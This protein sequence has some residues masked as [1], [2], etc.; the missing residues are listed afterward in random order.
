WRAVVPTWANWRRRRRDHG[1]PRHGGAGTRDR[2]PLPGAAILALAGPRVRPAQR[3]DGLG[4]FSRPPAARIARRRPTA[5]ALARDLGRRRGRLLATPDGGG[6]RRGGRPP[7]PAAA[8]RRLLP[9]WHPSRGDLRTG[10]DPAHCDLV[11]PREGRPV[12]L[13][14]LRHRA[15]DPGRHRRNRMAGKTRSNDRFVI[16]APRTNHLPERAF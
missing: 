13:D 2:Q 5:P 14:T 10:G 9:R 15:G 16:F 1:R 12:L 3:P 6:S 8:R 7:P 11:R 4:R